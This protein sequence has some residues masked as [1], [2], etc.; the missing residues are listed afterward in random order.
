MM[1]TT[2]AR[3]GEVLQEAR[4]L[5]AARR[6]ADFRWQHSRRDD[7]RLWR[8]SLEGS[9][10]VEANH[11]DYAY[12]FEALVSLYDTTVEPPWLERART[13]ADG[14]L[15]RLWDPRRAAST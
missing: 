9:A 12:L 8:A 5:N 11:N 1:I 4:Y 6:A 7:G 13:L 10:L 3:A 15:A 2:L 14:M